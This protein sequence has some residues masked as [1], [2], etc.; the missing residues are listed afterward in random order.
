MRVRRCASLAPRCR[1]LYGRAVRSSK[2]RSRAP[3]SPRSEPAAETTRPRRARPG[4]RI[5]GAP[6]AHESASACARSAVSDTAGRGPGRSGTVPGVGKHR[7]SRRLR[8]SCACAA[9]RHRGGHGALRRPL[10]VGRSAA[11]Q[12]QRGTERRGGVRTVRAAQRCSPKHRVVQ[13]LRREPTMGEQRG[14]ANRGAT[15]HR[16][17]SP[18]HECFAAVSSSSSASQDTTAPFPSAAVR[19]SSPIAAPCCLPAPSHR[20]GSGRTTDCSGP[21]GPCLLLPCDSTSQQLRA[22]MELSA[23]TLAFATEHWAA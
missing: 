19:Q 8:P 14:D 12:A 15:E 4:G 3:R 18:H 23:P 2:G 11:P 5:R 21:L 16:S 13:L 20:D 6:R 17:P 9:G 10:R 22:W 7:P 1:Q